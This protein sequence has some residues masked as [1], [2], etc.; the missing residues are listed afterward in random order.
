M[1]IKVEVTVGAVNCFLHLASAER[2]WEILKSLAWPSILYGIIMSCC[3][4]R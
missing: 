1:Q 3:Y 4:A 2:Y